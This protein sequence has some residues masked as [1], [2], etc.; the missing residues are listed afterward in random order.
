M[1]ENMLKYNFK[2]YCVVIHYYFACINEFVIRFK[3]IVSSNSIS[4]VICV[5]TPKI[6][7]NLNLK[8]IMYPSAMSLIIC[9]VI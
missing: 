4:L 9:Y 7:G 5:Y 2:V 1:F 6:C 8:N 3:H